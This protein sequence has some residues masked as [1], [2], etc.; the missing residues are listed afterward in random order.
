MNPRQY[1]EYHVNPPTYVKNLTETPQKKEFRILSKNKHGL[2]F[3][4]VNHQYN[5]P[6]VYLSAG[7]ENLKDSS[8]IWTL[9]PVD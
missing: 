6:H 1:K 2:L 3:A 8:D 5:N 4:G 9:E 7:I